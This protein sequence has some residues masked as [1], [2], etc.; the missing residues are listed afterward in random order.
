MAAEKVKDILALPMD[1]HSVGPKF[2]SLP[3]LRFNKHSKNEYLPLGARKKMQ[4]E[5]L[6]SVNQ[7]R[8]QSEERTLQ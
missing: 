2:L 3:E 8:Q 1:S 7:A 6:H 4:S 5:G